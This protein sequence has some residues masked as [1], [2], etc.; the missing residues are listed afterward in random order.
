MIA[1]AIPKISALEAQAA[2][3]GFLLDNLPDRYL[4]VEPRLDALTQVW[5]VKVVLT[6]PFIGAVGE[7]G[8]IVISASSE[9]V[10]SHTPLTEMR[11]R[12][13]QHYEQHCEAIQT[14]FSQAG[15]R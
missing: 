4:A 7:V 14:A 9:E 2:A 13:R 3:N 10:L 12:A 1:Q 5:R 15:N 11:E 6:Y 8:E